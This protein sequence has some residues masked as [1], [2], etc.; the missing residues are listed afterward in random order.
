MVL[1]SNCLLG[2]CICQFGKTYY[3]NIQ[4]YSNF[5][6]E[7][8]TEIDSGYKNGEIDYDTLYDTDLGNYIT[9]TKSAI[10][11]SMKHRCICR[12]AHK[13]F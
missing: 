10:C 4:W 7:N 3:K 9:C 8:I 5:K 2:S 13:A 11:Q 12:L 1:N 6:D